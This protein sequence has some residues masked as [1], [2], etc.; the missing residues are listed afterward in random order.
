M[1]FIEIFMEANLELKKEKINKILK[2]IDFYSIK[3]SDIDDIK[4]QIKDI[5]K[6][7]ADKEILN[8]I[9]MILEFHKFEDFFNE[10]SE[11]FT[12]TKQKILEKIKEIIK[13]SKGSINEKLKIKKYFNKKNLSD[14]KSSANVMDFYDLLEKDNDNIVLRNIIKQIYLLTGGRG[15]GQGENLLLA[16][17]KD[18]H[19]LSD[20]GDIIANG[21]KYEVKGRNSQTG[22]I[23]KDAN[24]FSTKANTK[25]PIVIKII[26]DVISKYTETDEDIVIPKD[27]KR[28]SLGTNGEFTGKVLTELYTK[29]N[30]KNR[31]AASK[32]IFGLIITLLFFVDDTH[33][34][35]DDL[36]KIYKSKEIQNKLSWLKGSDVINDFGL[37]NG[38][39]FWK[40]LLKINL[41]VYHQK[42]GWDEII[43]FNPQLKWVKGN[44]K[45]ISKLIDKGLVETYPKFVS[46]KDSQSENL[47]IR[48]I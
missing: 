24:H 11:K 35:L 8:Q 32:E 38:K 41:E 22:G 1:D 45:D 12:G 23:L 43:I 13:F 26:N 4:K 25:F 5:L 40:E 29:Y 21:V 14:I 33:I 17:F 9:L 34:A 31:K 44:I 18:T 42:A 15:I 10:L 19:P 16:F 28:Y 48:L 36:K 20:S 7:E 6:D 2:K 27:K 3:E 30:I 46:F 37:Y 47:K 39:I